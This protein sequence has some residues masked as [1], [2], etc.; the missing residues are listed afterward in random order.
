MSINVFVTFNEVCEK[1]V[2]RFRQIKT[3]KC[4]NVRREP[5][6]RRP[7]HLTTA[8]APTEHKQTSDLNV[9]KEIVFL[10]RDILAETFCTSIMLLYILNIFEYFCRNIFFTTNFINKFIRIWKLSEFVVLTKV[11][12]FF[13]YLRSKPAIFPTRHIKM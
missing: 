5:L 12:L 13:I 7:P 6:D 2:S 1:S 8:H 4:N 10:S 11:F 9:R 3:S